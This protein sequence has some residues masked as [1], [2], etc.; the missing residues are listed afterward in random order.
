VAK[1]AAKLTTVRNTHELTGFVEHIFD[2]GATIARLCIESGMHPEDAW[3]QGFS[4][5]E[6]WGKAHFDEAWQ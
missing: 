6:F 2:T 1:Q 5:I 4:F 3:C